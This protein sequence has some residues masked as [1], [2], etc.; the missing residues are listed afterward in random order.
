[1]I[2]IVVKLWAFIKRDFLVT[3]SYRFAFLLQMVG[4]LLSLP[5]VIAGLIIMMAAYR[6][7]GN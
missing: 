7:R 3:V 5:M 4:M 2:N 6:T 1:M